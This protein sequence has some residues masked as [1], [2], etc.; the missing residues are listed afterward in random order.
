[1]RLFLTA[2]FEKDYARLP[3]DFQTKAAI[4]LELFMGNPRHPSLHIKK[5]QGVRSIWEGR[6]SKAYR[7]TFILD[8]DLCIL[9]RVGTHAILRTP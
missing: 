5:V 7:F 9:R 6:V 4:A 3:T 1:M 8:G 2:S